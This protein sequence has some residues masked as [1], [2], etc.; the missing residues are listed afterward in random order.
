MTTTEEQGGK[1]KMVPTRAYKKTTTAA[2]T[3]T[4]TMPVKPTTTTTMAVCDPWGYFNHPNA[5]MIQLLF[6]HLYWLRSSQQTLGTAVT[7]QHQQKQLHQQRGQGVEQPGCTYTL[8]TDFWCAISIGSVRH[9]PHTTKS[10]TS[11]I[12]IMTL[13]HE[14]RGKVH[15]CRPDM[16]KADKQ[17]QPYNKFY[18][19]ISTSTLTYL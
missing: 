13:A 5:D 19:K 3:A 1:K 8:G 7:H 17:L 2:T 12:T 4:A 14:Y 15:F 18:L 10:G 9:P 16:C 6:N 11:T